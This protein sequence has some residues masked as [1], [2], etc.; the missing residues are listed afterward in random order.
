MDKRTLTPIVVAEHTRF[1][2]RATYDTN[3]DTIVSG[4]DSDHPSAKAVTQASKL[5][6]LIC[7]MNADGF[8][9]FNNLA[10]SHKRNLIWLLD[11]LADEVCALAELA[12]DLHIYPANMEASNE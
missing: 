9:V 4:I 7:L 1:D 11:D 12:S 5:S 3:G 10:D 8:D 2:T 6:A